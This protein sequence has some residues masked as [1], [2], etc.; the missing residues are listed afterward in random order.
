MTLILSGIQICI[1]HDQSKLPCG[2]FIR[3]TTKLTNYPTYISEYLL[4]LAFLL[5]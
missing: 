5:E 2:S 3:K 4:E 1:F